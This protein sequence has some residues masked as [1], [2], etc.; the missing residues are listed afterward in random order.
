MRDRCGLASAK[1]TVSLFR[2]GI[3]GKETLCDATGSPALLRLEQETE[4]PSQA[5]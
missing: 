1:E 3:E 5:S 4:L 2:D